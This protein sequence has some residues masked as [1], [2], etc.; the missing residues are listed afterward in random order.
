MATGIPIDGTP[1]AT[2]D[3]A[4]VYA[5][6]RNAGRLAGVFRYADELWHLGSKVGYD[7]AVVFAQFCE[8]TSTG[9]SRPWVEWLNP[10]RHRFCKMEDPREQHLL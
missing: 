2:V 4:K 5:R 6:K 3:A 9:T 7:P 8:E 10:F 1:T